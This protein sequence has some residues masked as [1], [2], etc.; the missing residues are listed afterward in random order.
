MDEE[1]PDVHG[2]GS[3]AWEAEINERV[4]ALYGL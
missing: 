3:E 2:V 1:V 4:A